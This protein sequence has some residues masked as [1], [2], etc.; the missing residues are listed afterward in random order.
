MRPAQSSPP[1]PIVSAHGPRRRFWP[2]FGPAALLVGSILAVQ[3]AAIS[4][5]VGTMT[6]SA[7]LPGVGERPMTHIPPVPLSETA[8]GP[9][10]LAAS[11]VV[12]GTTPLGARGWLYSYAGLRNWVVPADGGGTGVTAAAA[13]SS[14]TAGGTAPR[15][16][17]GRLT[18]VTAVKTNR[19]VLA[20]TFDC[21]SGDGALAQT[22]DVLQAYGVRV[23]FFV[24][25]DFAERYPELVR[26]I[27]AEGHEL[28]N[29]TQTHG[30]LAELS[31]NRIRQ[32]LRT[33]EETLSGFAGVTTKPLMRMP[34]GSR[35][36]R[37]LQIVNGEGYRSIYWS[38]DSGDWRE[39][40]TRAGVLQT[41]LKYSEA[42]DVVVQHCLPKITAQALPAI[43]D[44][45]AAQG[46]SV[47]TVSDLLRDE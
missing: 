36:P 8:P 30:D 25:G 22:L 12:S 26:R 18:E 34:F 44:G 6:G 5:T 29:H 28:A 1:T 43:L 2:V 20:L 33:T 40:A 16:V 35:D 38:L 11:D 24:T 3:T 32:E 46:L 47:V 9:A 10:G 37:V 15:Q 14:G 21:G 7:A 19:P 42:G 39:T 41:V 27:A 45:L 17:S 13:Q 31:D 23:T 4:A